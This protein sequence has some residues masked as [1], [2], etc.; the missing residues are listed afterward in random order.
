[1]MLQAPHPEDYVIAT[2]EMHSVRELLEV[3]FGHLGL[4]YRDHVVVDTQYL[5]P[6]EVDMLVGDYS[7]AHKQLGWEP[8]VSF[9][10]MIRLMVEA[11]IELVRANQKTS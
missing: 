1:M 8:T 7:K 3:A 4:D 6:A 5:R 2:G 11:D 10:E 9:E